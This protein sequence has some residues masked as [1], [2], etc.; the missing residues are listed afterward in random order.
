M[1]RGGRKSSIPAISHDTLRDGRK[2]DKQLDNKLY[3]GIPH[4]TLNMKAISR[5]G[6]RQGS[7]DYIVW[8]AKSPSAEG[9]QRREEPGQASGDTA[10]GV[11]NHQT[12]KGSNGEKRQGRL[13]GTKSP[14]GK[15]REGRGNSFST[16]SKLMVLL[17]LGGVPG[18]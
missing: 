14:G 10:F 16:H 4:P 18:Q 9:K 15:V 2:G 17:Q 1:A 7:M 5:E 11:P 8:C 13:W 6:P 12:G 3:F